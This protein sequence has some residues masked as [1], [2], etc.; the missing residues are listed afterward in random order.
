MAIRFWFNSGTS[1][2][3]RKHSYQ[4]QA[5]VQVAVCRWCSVAHGAA[6][7]ARSRTAPLSDSAPLVFVSVC[8]A[9]EVACLGAGLSY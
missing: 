2:Q 4:G 9:S 5:R 6:P 7:A 1:N 3:A 8:P